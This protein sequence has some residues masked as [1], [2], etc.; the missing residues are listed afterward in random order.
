MAESKTYALDL[1]KNEYEYLIETL[2]SALREATEGQY[3]VDTAAQMVLGDV[4][5]QLKTQAQNSTAD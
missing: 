5:E 2:E 3:G 4:L 1:S